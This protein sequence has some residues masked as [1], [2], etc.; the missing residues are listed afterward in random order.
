MD[1]NELTAEDIQMFSDASKN[2][3]KGMGAICQ[4]DWMCMQ[5][6][7]TFME[8]NDPNIEFLELYAVT[9][10]ILTWIHHFKNCRVYLFCNNM[11]VA[12]M[13]NNSSSNV[14]TS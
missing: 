4:N 2:Y 11:S 8:R 5:W 9:A 14:G 10:A 6:D 13:L 7:R 3:L 12:H 1:F